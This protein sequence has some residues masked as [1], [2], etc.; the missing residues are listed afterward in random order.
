VLQHSRS[1][2]TLLNDLDVSTE[3]LER[4]VRD[5]Q[6]SPA[7]TQLYLESEAPAV[8]AALASLAGLSTKL[9]STLRAGLEQ[10]FAQ[11]VR[12]R[13]RT[14]IPDV[15]RDAAYAGAGED[16]D[17]GEVPRRFARALDALLDGFRGPLTPGNFA[18]FFALLLD[19]LVR[20]WERHVLGLRFSERG[21][22]RFD[23]EVRAV[24]AHLAEMTPF[25]DV[26]EKMARLGQVAM[27]LNLD[28]VRTWAGRGQ[29]AGLT[30]AVGGG[31][32]GVLQR[33][34]HQLEAERAGGADGRGAACLAHVGIIRVPFTTEGPRR[35]RSRLRRTERY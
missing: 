8:R 6:A 30:R 19:A 14:L 15:Y 25:G 18:R 9:T 17:A 34:G 10:L 11:L 12:P 2:Q 35:S 16:G 26:R 27:V 20:P 31:R 28:T 21:A 7:I 1:A 22:V 32:G 3:H 4:L 24:G 29:G 33:L 13:L 5:A 23:R